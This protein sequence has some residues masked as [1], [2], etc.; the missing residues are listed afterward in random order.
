MWS[1][2][3]TCLQPPPS[4]LPP[5]P[6]A[7][8][9]AAT[10]LERRPH[11]QRRAVRGGAVHLSPRRPRVRLGHRPRRA[12]PRAAG[13]PGPEAHAAP[14]GAGAG[15]RVHRLGHVRGRGGRG[16]ADARHVPGRGGAEGPVGPDRGRGP[17]VGAAGCGAAAQCPGACVRA[18][19][20]SGKCS[21]CTPAV[22][23]V[24]LGTAKEGATGCLFRSSAE[25]VPGV[26]GRPQ[27]R[28]DVSRECQK[29]NT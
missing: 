18:C 12:G 8:R 17:A 27:G 1:A 21:K 23:V 20:R 9:A 25:V 11:A 2:L 5:A 7:H 24:G 19:V 26:Q 14:A 29:K 13:S 4:A 22:C 16:A 6:R 28:S 3:L 15:H 10:R